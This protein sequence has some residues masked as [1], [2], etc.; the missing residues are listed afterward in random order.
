MLVGD[1]PPTAFLAQ[2]N[3]EPQAPVGVLLELA[4]L[5]AAQ[6]RVREGDVGASRDLE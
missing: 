2:A 3:G 5:P 1:E 4:R 6:K